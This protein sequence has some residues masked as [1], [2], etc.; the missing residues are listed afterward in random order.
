V[1]LDRK[2]KTDNIVDEPKSSPRS[3]ALNKPKSDYE[4]RQDEVKELLGDVPDEMPF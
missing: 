4:K 3:Q 1:L 2:E